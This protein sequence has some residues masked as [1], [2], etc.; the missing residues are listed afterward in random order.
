VTN[1]R[2]NAL[3]RIA[4]RLVTGPLAFLVGWVLDVVVLLGRWVVGRFRGT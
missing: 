4:G 2:P 1:A 3:S